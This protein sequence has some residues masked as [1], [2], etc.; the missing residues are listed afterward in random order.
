MTVVR[1][2]PVVLTQALIVPTL[3]ALS[4]LAHLGV[5]A[6]AYLDA[7]LLAIGGFVAAAFVSVDA[8]L[9]ALAGL[10]KA[11]FALLAGL[12]LNFDPVLQTTVMGVIAAA[13]AFY[14]RT[15]VAASA[16][17]PVV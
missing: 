5:D 9:P 4:L 13:T 12:G 15:Q 17:P 3:M 10:A 6:Q 11:V 14:V 8:A 2:D 1:R 16:A 7:A